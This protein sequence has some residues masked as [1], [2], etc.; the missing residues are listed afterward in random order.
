MN[1]SQ[2]ITLCD[3][4]NK[5][6]QFNPLP[7]Y[8]PISVKEERNKP[9]YNNMD[10][11][12]NTQLFLSTKN[13][14]GMCKYIV[15]RNVENMTQVNHKQIQKIIPG[16]MRKW[17]IETNINDYED[18]HNN[19]IST[20]R[21][22]NEKFLKENGNLYGRRGCQSL[23]V[24]QNMGQVTDKCGRQSLKKYDDMLAND[25]HTIDMW[26]PQTTTR[27][28]S[29]FRYGNK[30]PMWQQSMNRRH[31]DTSNDG[32]HAAEYERA[33]LNNQ[34]HGYDMSNIVKGANY[35]DNHFYENP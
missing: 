17:A 11:I 25:Y 31:Y 2:M 27:E 35:Y 5:S 20:M 33:S 34:I 22:L 26:K 19:P 13:I 6:S 4:N 14:F 18:M 12:S 1:Q 32:L 7:I 30:I 3:D 16:Q 21:Y 9:V 28:D 8:D 29:M 23:N 10:C 24:F 15:A